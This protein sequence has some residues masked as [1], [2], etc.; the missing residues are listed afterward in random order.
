MDLN[1]FYF[2]YQLSLIK[3]DEAATCDLRQGH[4]VEAARIAGCIGLWQ[5]RLGAAAANAW[6]ARAWGQPA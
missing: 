5:A 1:R 4:Q 2:D 6:I 3:A